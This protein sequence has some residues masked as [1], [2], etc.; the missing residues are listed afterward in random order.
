MQARRPGRNY[1]F[2]PGPT[3]VPDRVQ[4]AMVVAMEDHRSSTFPDL[5]TSV[6]HDLKRVFKTESGQAFI[7]PSSGTG[8]WEAALTNTLSPGDRI[9][10]A[11]FGQFSHLWID[12]AQRLGFD[13]EALDVEW[14]EG[15]PLDRYAEILRADKRHSIKGVLVCHNETATGVT[16]DVAGVRRALDEAGH[17]ALLFVDA[18]SS[19]ASIDFRMEEWGVDLAV[20]G[21]QKGLMMPAG[22]GILAVSQKA[23]KAIPAAQS[24]RCYF[25]LADMIKANATG[26]FPYTPALP[27]LYGLRE[28]LNIIFEEGLEAIFARHH[29]LAEG[30][31]AAIIRGWRLGL[32]ARDPKWYSDTV[33]AV[34][35]PAGMN[36]AHVIDVAFRRYNL[37][38]GAGLAKVA[39]KVFRIGHLGDLNELMLMGAIAGA[40]MAMLDVGIEVTP[41]SGVAAASN[42]WRSHDPTPRK[43]VS[44]EEQFY[45]SHS[46]GSIQG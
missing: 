14:G 7:F 1:L 22:L 24:R 13:V 15:V 33:S 23:L 25:D 11:R 41:G 20:S 38:L 40:E 35:V 27:M 17:P 43:R 34:V 3:N 5:S 45:E 6:L 4:R 39:G 26:Y 21:S 37:A 31:R 18:V 29:Y 19:L 8:A 10:A 42:Y 36:G 30:V 16:S 2:V 28:S 32:C 12:M 46:T 44:R 9:L